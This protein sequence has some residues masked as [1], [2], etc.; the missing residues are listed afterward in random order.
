MFSSDSITAVIDDLQTVNT[1]G[2]TNR[3]WE[4]VTQSGVLEVG[5]VSIVNSL[6][7]L[8]LTLPTGVADGSIVSAYAQLGLF[9][10]A[11]TAGVQVQVGNKKTTIGAGGSID[12]QS[13]GDYIELVFANGAW[14]MSK[15]VG[16]VDVR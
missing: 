11:Q 1:G 10:I 4:V 9:R 15:L 14:K 16:Y 8:T 5:K 7:L 2:G 6:S 3:T 12:S 13:A